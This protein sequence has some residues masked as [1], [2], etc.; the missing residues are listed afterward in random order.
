[1]K[2][3]LSAAVL[4]VLVVGLKADRP[5]LVPYNAIEVDPFG[6]NPGVGLPPAYE[7]AIADDIARQASI[8]YR[9]IMVLHQGDPPPTGA[10]VLRVTGRV[11]RFTPGNRTKRLL[12]P[13]A[14]TASIE[15]IVQ[16]TDA[17]TGQLLFNG[18]FKGAAS[19][20]AQ[21]GGESASDSLAKKIV[22]L[23]NAAHLIASN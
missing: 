1:M 9:T 7:T 15:A 14:G 19:A 18:E 13:F 2:V 12:V 8:E 21:N 23:C 22:K 16:F 20:G 6:A 5:P 10:R 17:T 11:T 4:C 3:L